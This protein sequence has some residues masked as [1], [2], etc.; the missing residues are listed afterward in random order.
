MS[1]HCAWYWSYRIDPSLDGVVLLVAFNIFGF[2]TM[3]PSIFGFVNIFVGWLCAVSICGV[4]WSGVLSAC[5]VVVS[6]ALFV[7]GWP[8]CPFSWALQIPFRRLMLWRLSLTLW[9]FAWPCRGKPCGW[10]VGGPS[11]ELN[12]A[13]DVAKAPVDFL[14]NCLAS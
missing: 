1:Q 11:V 10:L 2:V 7:I 6:M 13:V 4:A 5:L 9:E 14:G 3:V 8:S 12:E